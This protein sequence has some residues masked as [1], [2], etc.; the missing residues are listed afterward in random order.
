MEISHTYTILDEGEFPNTAIWSEGR[1]D[2]L[3]SVRDVYWPPRN[4]EFL[5]YPE[6]NENGV[7]P[8]TEQFE[9]NLDKKSNWE[10][11]G[12][13][14]LSGLLEERGI[15]DETLE[16]MGEYYDDPLDFLSSPWFDA[17][18]EVEMEREQ[19]LI[20]AEWETGNISSSHR[21]LNRIT[22]G[23]MSGIIHGGLI[24]LPNRD[25]YYYLTDRIGNYRELVPYFVIWESLAH[26]VENGIIE[27]VVV[28]H[29][30]VSDSV[31]PIGKLTDGMSDRKVDKNAAIG[32]TDGDEQAGLEEY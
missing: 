29:D 19:G 4:D 5:V 2:V 15:L 30:G 20:V 24:V 26:E 10:S 28:E 21:S 31:P 3:D 12:R 7:N 18:K 25:L 9:A 17:M 23:L 32:T 22:L 8:I 16:K 14:W 1:E 27:V 13:K 11:T 6:E